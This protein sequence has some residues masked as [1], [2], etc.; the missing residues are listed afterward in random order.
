MSDRIIYTKDE[1]VVIRTILR[2]A[3]SNYD[4][5][6]DKYVGIVIRDAQMM[7]ADRSYR[8]RANKRVYHISSFLSRYNSGL[9]NGMNP[10]SLGKED[11]IKLLQF[12]EEL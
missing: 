4:N 6:H 10:N 1:F 3:V 7:A 9:I 11:Y 5:Y 2:G 12:F 8:Y